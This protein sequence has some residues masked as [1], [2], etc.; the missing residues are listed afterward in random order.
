[1]VANSNQ[2]LRTRL[3]I[4]SINY[5]QLNSF[6]NVTSFSVRHCL[7]SLVQSLAYW[8][9]QISVTFLRLPRNL[10]HEGKRL[11]VRA[12]V[13]VEDLSPIHSNTRN[14][15]VTRVPNTADVTSTQRL[16]FKACSI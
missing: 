4:K 2:L 12:W 6:T 14:K 10:R 16:T 9:H 13:S 8:G 1:M 15:V 11:A 5:K 7:H 3:L